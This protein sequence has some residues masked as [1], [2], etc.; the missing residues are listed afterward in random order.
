MASH[1]YAQ[2]RMLRLKDALLATMS[3]AVYIDL[4][5]KGFPKPVD[6]YLQNPDM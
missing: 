1:A 5:L 3:L 2:A 6:A 4:K